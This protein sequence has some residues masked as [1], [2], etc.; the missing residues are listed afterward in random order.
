MDN[1]QEEFLDLMRRVQ[2]GDEQAAEELYESYRANIL[3]VVRRRLHHP[4]RNRFDSCDF[5]QSVWMSFYGRGLEKTPF[6]SPKE[7]AAF[8]Q[9]MAL[10]KVV[11]ACRKG[12]QTT[13]YDC[14][15]ERSLQE[16]PSGGIEGAPEAYLAGAT[17]TPS[18]EAVANE[19]WEDLMRGRS[20]L[21]RQILLLRR[22]GRT[23]EE[24]G[25]RLNLSPK[26]VQRLLRRLKP[27]SAS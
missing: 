24:I 6:E 21:D 7:L 11:Q 20:A 9:K 5:V 2:E 26:R 3:R 17:P 19:R 13:R 22:E 25:Q 14:S 1:S 4:L 16:V 10:F 18:Q 15:N 12:M 23:Y 8:L 27:K